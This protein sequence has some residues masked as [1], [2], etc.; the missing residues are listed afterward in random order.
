MKFT[1]VPTSRIRR[2]R[3]SFAGVGVLDAASFV[4]R[5]V[6]LAKGGFDMW[7][8]DSKG[9][10]YMAGQEPICGICEAAGSWEKDA[11]GGW[12]YVTATVGGLSGNSY[13]P[14]HSSIAL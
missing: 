13:I 11:E 12:V 7:L 14:V 6:E 9:N 4:L 10:W 2:S 8:K 3:R 1:T 5:P